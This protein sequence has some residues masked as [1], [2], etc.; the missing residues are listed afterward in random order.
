MTTIIPPL[1]VVLIIFL[2][3]FDHA[4]TQMLMQVYFQR[5]IIFII[6]IVAIKK[7][8]QFNA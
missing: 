1:T 5:T 6:N 2:G 3:S 8:K 7:F 4:Q